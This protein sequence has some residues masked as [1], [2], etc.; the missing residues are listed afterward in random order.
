MYET[1]PG[2]RPANVENVL[3]NSGQAVASAPGRP[4]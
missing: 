1:L 2:K 4:H 3:V